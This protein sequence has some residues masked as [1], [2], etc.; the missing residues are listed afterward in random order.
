MIISGVPTRLSL[1]NPV[2]LSFLCYNSA[3]ARLKSETITSVDQH[4]SMDQ[5]D[6][7]LLALPSYPRRIAGLRPTSK[8]DGPLVLGGGDRLS[9]TNQKAENSP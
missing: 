2:V 1:T 5:R 4:H 9:L 3:D 8:C 6:F 7:C